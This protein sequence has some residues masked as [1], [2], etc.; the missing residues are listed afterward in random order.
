MGRLQL[1]LGALTSEPAG[2]AGHAPLTAV[3]LVALLHHV[4]ADPT[5]DDGVDPVGDEARAC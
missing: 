2:V 1:R 3:L 4:P 5:T